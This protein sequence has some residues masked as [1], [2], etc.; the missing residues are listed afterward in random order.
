MR[1]A[2]VMILI[3]Q[4]P[5]GAER[6]LFTRRAATIEFQ[7]GQVSFPGGSRE[8]DER[9]AQTALRETAEEI[10][11]PPEK[12]T[13]T[14]EYEALKLARGSFRVTPVTGTWNGDMEALTLQHTE[15]ANAAN[16]PVSMLADPANRA[17]WRHPDGAT[18][19][20]FVIDGFY[21]WGFT[22]YV[23]TLWLRR[24]GLERPWDTQRI[25]EVPT[26]FR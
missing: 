2:A 13:V 16:I 19:P 7:G 23:A 3:S 15:V 10:G 12:I 24:N 9:P 11:L 4:D 26:D 14:G 18:G 1:L 25:V 22:A 21:I 8:G 5:D 6:M 20:V 17:S